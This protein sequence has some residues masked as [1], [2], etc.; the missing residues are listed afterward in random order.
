MELSS[1]HVTTGN[2]AAKLQNSNG[3][4]FVAYAGSSMNPTLCEPEIME[5][6]PY[7]G[8][9]LRIGDV[10]LFLPPESD[11]PVVHRI[12]RV[13]PAGI[14]TRGDNNAHEDSFLLQPDN[15]KGRVV[16]AWR[17]HQTRRKVAGGLH[18]RL[19]SRRIRWERVLD[20]GVSPLLH[21]LYQALSRWNLIAW[22]LPVPF[23]PRVVV[24]R[25]QGGDQF[26]L[27]LG[28]RIIGRYDDQR[29]QWLIQRPFQLFV[30]K[31]ALPGRQDKEHQCKF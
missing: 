18:G 15:I 12:I 4:F 8:R 20:C 30:D 1:L 17:G 2:A 24:F 9:P 5:I 16:A 3:M 31:R 27:L 26:Q 23:R 13:T 14:S 29:R 7:A 25:R 10:A 28:Q 22:I 11:Q 19:T 21:P 6:M